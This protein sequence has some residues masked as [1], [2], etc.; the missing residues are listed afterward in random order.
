MKPIETRKPPMQIV[1]LEPWASTTFPTMGEK[2]AIKIHIA[3][4]PPIIAV[5]VQE[6]SACRS[7]INKLKE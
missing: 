2:T 5:R 6:K 3:V 7:L 4:K 1:I